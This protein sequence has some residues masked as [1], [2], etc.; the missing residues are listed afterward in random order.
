MIKDLVA[1]NFGITNAS[2]QDFIVRGVMSWMWGATQVVASK[3]I[4]KVTP[5]FIKKM[6]SGLQNKLGTAL[7]VVSAALNLS[8]S[9]SMFYYASE[10]NKASDKLES[11]EL[12]RTFINHLVFDYNGSIS[13]LVIDLKKSIPTDL[14]VRY[15]NVE[16]SIFSPDCR[17]V[18]YSPRLTTLW[19]VYFYYMK[20]VVGIDT[21]ESSNVYLLKDSIFY[22]YKALS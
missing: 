10:L 9:F 11:M 14:V 19:E 16:G 20:H 1:D 5:E 13:R 22:V 18:P 8:E 21:E 17:D 12:A 2:Q 4:E 6:G 3:G 7:F 15:C